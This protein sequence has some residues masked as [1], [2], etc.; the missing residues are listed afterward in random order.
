MSKA[1]LN[2]MFRREHW[3]LTRRYFVALGGAALAAS[4]PRSLVRAV[5]HDQPEPAL[6]SKPA[7]AGALRD[8]YF[9][10]P[11][12][13]R[14]VSRGKPLPQSLSEDKRREVGLTRDTWRLEI[15]ADPDQPARLGKP[16]TKATGTAI[17]FQQ[18]VS[19]GEAHSVRFAKVMTCLNLGCPLGMG[20]WEGV[21]L[22]ELVWRTQ[23]RENLRR[24]FYHGYHND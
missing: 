10:P 23:P 22:R 6:A 3:S 17:D 15:L 5:E 7:K 2:E 9:T 8:P 18:L 11:A 1:D 14:D 4:S 21:P 19:L 24:V 13:F 12:H 20:L 16:L